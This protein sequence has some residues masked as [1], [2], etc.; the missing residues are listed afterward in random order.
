[1]GTKS[2]SSQWHLIVTLTLGITMPR[3][4]DNATC[5]TQ[6]LDTWHFYFLKKIK[7]KIKNKKKF[8]IVFK[9]N[10]KNHR[11]T[12]GTLTNGVS[13]LCLKGT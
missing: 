6:G 13:Q 9:K 4:T 1:M 3:G 10:Q 2:K 12:R 11:L 7:N 8:K 5:H